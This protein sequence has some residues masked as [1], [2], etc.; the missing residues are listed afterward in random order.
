MSII[1]WIALLPFLLATAQLVTMK[2]AEMREASELPLIWRWTAWLWDRIGVGASVAFNLLLGWALFLEKP[3]PVREWTFSDRVR[4]HFYFEPTSEP[5]YEPL[6]VKY[7][8][9]LAGWLREQINATRK[10]HI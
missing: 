4:R 1:V 7:R 8:E 3:F 9:W 10:D 5:S 6:L 2:A